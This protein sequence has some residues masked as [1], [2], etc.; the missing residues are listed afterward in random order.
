MAADTDSTSSGV[1]FSGSFR[2]LGFAVSTD[3]TGFSASA[4]SLIFGFLPGFAFGLE[5]RTGG[6][7]LSCGQSH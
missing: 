6:F 4:S 7:S 2:P 5:A 3:S 1:S